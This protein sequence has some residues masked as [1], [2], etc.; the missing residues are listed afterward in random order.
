MRHAEAY[1]E[2]KYTRKVGENFPVVEHLL[3]CRIQDSAY[4]FQRSRNW[5]AHPVSYDRKLRQAE[6]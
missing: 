5:K 1:G 3:F 2:K 4:L 6:G